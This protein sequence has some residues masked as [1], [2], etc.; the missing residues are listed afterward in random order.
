[1]IGRNV[2]RVLVMN[3]VALAGT[4]CGNGT[5]P[6]RRPVDYQFALAAV[7]GD[8]TAERARTYDCSVYGH[9]SLPQP[10][11]PAGTVRFPVRVERRLF[12]SR[13]SHTEMTSADTNIS[14][15]VLDYTGLG[16]DSLQFVIGAGSYTVSLGPGGRALG[17][18]TEYAGDW[19]C[20]PEVPLG[21]DS[22][23]LAYGYGAS[24]RLPGT[25]RVSEIL[26]ID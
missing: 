18:P 2:S 7:A 26:P 22:T 1:M 20:G 17:S 10:L 15:L 13:G 8:T 25:W 4:G 9:F 3:L 24:L 19:S 6:S 11:S 14:E 12:E 23:L 16:D 5:D 21:Q